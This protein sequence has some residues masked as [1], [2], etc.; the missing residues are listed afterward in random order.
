MFKKIGLLVLIVLGLTI[1]GV[2]LF[3]KDVDVKLTE[4]QVNAAI[5]Q[6]IINGPIRSRGVELTVKS[7]TV[8]FKANNTAALSI[9]FLADGFGYK[10]NMRGDFATGIRYD[11]PEIFLDNIV[12]VQMELG[13]D[14][15]TEGKLQ[16][17]KNVASDLLERQKRDM[18]SDKAK[19]S[20]DNIVG[21]NEDVLKEFAI[22]ATYGFFETLPV[23][24]LNDLG[25][26]GSLASLALKDVS[27]TE[28]DAI[29]SLSPVQALIKILSFC[30]ISLLTLWY[31]LGFYIPKR[32]V[33]SA[34]S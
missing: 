5:N 24:D 21:S 20:L 7:A 18:L 11:A 22:K 14:A 8:D 17:I 34:D 26:K 28:H 2:F 3:A 6:K 1:L 33:K 30:A 16:D 23:Y 32:R 4:D 10:G 31:L 29:I 12:P 13:V 27:F 19:E 9:D 25:V 15:E